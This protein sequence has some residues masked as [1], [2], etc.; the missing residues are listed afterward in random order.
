MLVSAL[1]VNRGKARLAGA[2]HVAPDARSWSLIPAKEWPP[3]RYEIVI[4]PLLEDLAGNNLL[5]PFE[6]DRD[7]PVQ[8]AKLSLLKFEVR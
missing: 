2:M 7:L 4:D 6:V 5:G 1:S 3:G 8:P